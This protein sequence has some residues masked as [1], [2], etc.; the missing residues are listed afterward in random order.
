MR[1]LEYFF[2]DNTVYMIGGFIFKSGWD[3]CILE[4][5]RLFE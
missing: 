4:Y 2:S 3:R 5:G 1:L